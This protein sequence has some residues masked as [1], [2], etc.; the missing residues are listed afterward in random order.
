MKVILIALVFSVWEGNYIGHDEIAKYENMQ[1][2]Q[3]QAD[4]LNKRHVRYICVQELVK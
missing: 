3:T 4:I 1:I 2:C